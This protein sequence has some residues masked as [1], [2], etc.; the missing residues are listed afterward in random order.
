MKLSLSVV[1]VV[2]VVVFSILLTGSLDLLLL[3]VLWRGTYISM[4]AMQHVRIKFFEMMVRSFQF[5]SRRV[6]LLEWWWWCVRHL[7]RARQTID[8]GEHAMAWTL[9]AWVKGAPIKVGIGAH[10]PFPGG[11]RHALVILLFTRTNKC[12]HLKRLITN[13]RKQK[14]M[15][16]VILSLPH[17]ITIEVNSSHQNSN[18]LHKFLK[19]H[20]QI[21]RSLHWSGLHFQS[22]RKSEES[23]T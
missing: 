16:D 17:K 13:N 4:L 6:C 21:L 10:E 20:N 14:N 18:S 12:S 9:Y 19:F 15:N 11:T 3:E 22:S 23:R 8:R 1:N 5:C 7:G 2:L